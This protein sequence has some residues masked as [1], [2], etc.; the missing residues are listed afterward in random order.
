[1]KVYVSRNGNDGLAKFHGRSFQLIGSGQPGGPDERFFGKDILNVLLYE[2]FFF[3]V[4]NSQRRLP[5]WRQIHVMTRFLSPSHVS[6]QQGIYSHFLQ[7]RN[8]VPIGPSPNGTNKHLGSQRYSVISQ[9]QVPEI[10]ECK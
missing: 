9:Y 8:Q 6:W 2:H 1:M 10:R 4:N 3:N 7:A 5:P